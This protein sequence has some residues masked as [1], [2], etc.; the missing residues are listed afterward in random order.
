M[1]FR[2][3][4]NPLFLALA[5]ADEVEGNLHLLREPQGLYLDRLGRA[6]VWTA[7]RCHT[8]AKLDLNDG[9]RQESLNQG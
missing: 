7:L 3:A 8:N 9:K 4:F 1:A 2:A 5:L 6:F